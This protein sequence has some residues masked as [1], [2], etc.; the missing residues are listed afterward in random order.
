MV[1]FSEFTNVWLGFPSYPA[2]IS[3][4]GSAS[5]A[6]WVRSSSNNSSN[7]LF[8]ASI[9][10]SR[11]IACCVEAVRVVHDTRNSTFLR[12]GRRWRNAFRRRHGRRLGRRRRFTIASVLHNFV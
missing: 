4:N 9:V 7:F 2:W 1:G 11:F 12:R 6:P 8:A 10:S 3:S 5:S